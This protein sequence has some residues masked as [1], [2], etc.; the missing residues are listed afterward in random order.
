M[1]ENS[2]AIAA[3]LFLARFVAVEASYQAAK[4]TEAGFRYPVGI[5]M[6]IAFRVGGPLLMFAGYKIAGQASTRI[7]WFLAAA[8]ALMGL[9]C[10]LGEPG[11]IATSQT[12]LIQR[13]YLGLK[14][15]RVAW[16]GAAARYVPE[17]RQVFVIG[18]DGTAITHSQYHVGQQQLIRQLEKHGVFVQGLKNPFR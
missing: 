7:D 2:L 10:I 18:E 15:R 11:E 4:R 14:R 8:V 9:G 16:A 1:F 6:R 3:A 5:G 12:G 13:T 17:Q